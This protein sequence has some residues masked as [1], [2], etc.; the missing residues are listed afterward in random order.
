MTTIFADRQF[1]GR[2]ADGSDLIIPNIVRPELDEANA[3]RPR[4][5]RKP[6]MLV[7]VKQTT[8]D[9]G[10][11]ATV[12]LF[13]A[14]VIE[15]DGEFVKVRPICGPTNDKIDKIVIKGST[16]VAGVNKIPGKYRFIKVPR[17]AL[18]LVHPDEMSGPFMAYAEW[19][20]RNCVSERFVNWKE[21]FWKRMA[22]HAKM[23]R[24]AYNNRDNPRLGRKE[25]IVA[26]STLWLN[27][28]AW[29]RDMDMAEKIRSFFVRMNHVVEGS[30]T[31]WAAVSRMGNNTTDRKLVEIWNLRMHKAGKPTKMLSRAGCG[32][33]EFNEQAVVV[34]NRSHDTN[35]FC[36]HCAAGI[37]TIMALDEE[38]NEVR[39]EPNVRLYTW[40]D[41]TRRLSS[42]PSVIGSY[43]SSK[44]QCGALPNLDGTPFIGVTMGMELEMEMAESSDLDRE[45]A[46]RRVSARVRAARPEA[47]GKAHRSSRP[48]Y[49]F[50]ENDGSLNNGFEMVTS[51]GS[52]DVHRDQVLK[53]FGPERGSNRLPYKGIL[54][55]HDGPGTCGLHVHLS[56]P[57][58]L[59][60][61]VKLQAFYNDPQN[62][63]LV[64]SVARRYGT[65]Y[66]KAQRSKNKEAVAATA[67]QAMGG[68]TFKKWKMNYGHNK[69]QVMQQ[70][71]SR[72]CDD[73][74]YSQVNFTNPHTVEIRVFKGTLL[75]T[76]IIACLEFA[77]AVYMFTKEAQAAQLTTEDFLAW[78]SMPVNRRDTKYL[79]GYLATK[80][81]S[82]FQPKP[83]KGVV[84]RQESEEARATLGDA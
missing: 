83:N 24:A 67:K 25:K 35:S 6:G 52:L 36:Q 58:S 84:N 55:S 17:S 54:R 40:E 72:L 23:D 60:H 50:F 33:F 61:A 27:P 76:T 82:V 4:Q 51:Y 79:R 37:T 11:S 63:K 32:H 9:W 31:L 59:M 7:R 29:V 73:S 34:R 70:A 16:L 3:I 66:A 78:I 21:K 65:S 49:A 41:G 74:R 68:M 14:I 39:C 22:D 77:Y 45:E 53:I 48:G 19:N 2:A 71:M 10:R 8:M 69:A 18:S 43:H 62:E 46:A 47:W 56:K 42:P 13:R 75:P 44:R 80:G 30:S 81:F 20:I 1:T 5:T 15:V 64:K 57:T 38:G 12:N 28:R 26:G